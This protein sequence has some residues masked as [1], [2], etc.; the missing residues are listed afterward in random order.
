M[1][2]DENTIPDVEILAYENGWL[3]VSA[4]WQ[5][6]IPSTLPDIRETTDSNV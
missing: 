4:S 6:W 3:Y 2:F 1:Q 5:G